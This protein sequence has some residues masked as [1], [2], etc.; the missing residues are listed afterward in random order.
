MLTEAMTE[1]EPAH[2]VCVRLCV[3]VYIQL[4]AENAEWR[5]VVP[6]LRMFWVQNRGVER[7]TVHYIRSIR[8]AWDKG[9][10]LK[11]R[12]ASWREHP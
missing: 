12:T 2:C 8:G 7:L 9:R 4:G 11:G 6:A 5:D 1:S 3:Y 10:H